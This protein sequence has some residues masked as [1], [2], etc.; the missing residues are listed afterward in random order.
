M[1]GRFARWTADL[2]DTEQAQVLLRELLASRV[3]VLGS[4][5]PHTEETQGR[6]AK[7]HGFPG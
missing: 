2:C 6:L 5:H 1:S 3:R 7:I 4:A